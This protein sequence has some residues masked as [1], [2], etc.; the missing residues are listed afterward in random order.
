M[1]HFAWRWKEKN[2]FTFL[3]FQF[4]CLYV[5]V[6]EKKK[7]NSKWLIVLDSTIRTIVL[8]IDQLVWVTFEDELFSQRQ[9]V[10][11]VT[12]IIIIIIL[13]NDD[14]SGSIV[15]LGRGKP[16]NPELRYFDSNAFGMICAYKYFFFYTSTFINHVIS[17][18]ILYFLI[19][20]QGR[21]DW[22]ISSKRNR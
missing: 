22:P 10:T 3:S 11:V 5:K 13:I 1:S 14:V 8:W 2:F 18:L 12:Y 21:V 20:K 17:L 6:F 7:K 16:V 19:T 15:Y 9:T 4:R